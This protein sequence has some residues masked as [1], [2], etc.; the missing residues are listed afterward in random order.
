MPTN[1]VLTYYCP[2]LSI[3]SWIFTNI[4]DVFYPFTHYEKYILF[5]LEA[6]LHDREFC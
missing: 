6:T 3:F 5:Y 4:A 1:E 2:E